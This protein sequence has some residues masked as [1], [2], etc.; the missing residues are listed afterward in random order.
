MLRLK[1][2]VTINQIEVATNLNP[3]RCPK[4]CEHQ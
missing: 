1:K 4:E 2:K 3:I